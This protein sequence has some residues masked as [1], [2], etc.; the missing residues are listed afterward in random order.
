MIIQQNLQAH[1]AYSNAD[2]VA[3][4][5]ASEEATMHYLRTK[6]VSQVAELG[7]VRHNPRNWAAFR[8]PQS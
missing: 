8:S 3:Y 7:L 5:T 2:I 6:L 1:H 4:T